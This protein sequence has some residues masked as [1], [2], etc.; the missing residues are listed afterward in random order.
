[1]VYATPDE[2]VDGEFEPGGDAPAEGLKVGALEE[3]RKPAAARWRAGSG[4]D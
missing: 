1:V 2:G 4:G 3:A